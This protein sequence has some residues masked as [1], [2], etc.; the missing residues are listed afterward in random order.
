MRNEGVIVV[1]FMVVISLFV[2]YAIYA[3]VGI[4]PAKRAE[5]ATLQTDNEELKKNN[6]ELQKINLGLKSAMNY[7]KIF[8][9]LAKPDTIMLLG[10]LEK[11]IKEKG[12][13]CLEG[14]E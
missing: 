13:F 5:I 4:L 3:G 14:V 11:R 6:A 7:E 10:D 9:L 2:M 1:V 12:E 8:L